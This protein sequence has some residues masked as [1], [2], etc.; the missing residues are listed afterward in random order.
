MGE[1]VELLVV[2][3]RWGLHYI[4]G[5]KG[6]SARRILIQVVKKADFD[7]KGCRNVRVQKLVVVVVRA[8]QE[9]DKR[10]AAC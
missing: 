4:D 5:G 2:K 6:E 10:D 3:D 1:W 9:Q 8:V 7:S